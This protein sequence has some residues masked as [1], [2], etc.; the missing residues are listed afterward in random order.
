[1]GSV[2]SR[3]G[4]EVTVYEYAPSLASS[5][6]VDLVVNLR[7][8]TKQGIAFHLSTSVMAL[9]KKVRRWLLLLSK[10]KSKR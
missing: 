5:M 8:L 4:T 10:K 1:M 2:Y 3:L 7:V 6:D 9:R